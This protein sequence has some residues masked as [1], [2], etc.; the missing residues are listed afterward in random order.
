ML[1]SLSSTKTVSELKIRAKIVELRL[2]IT[3]FHLFKL[4]SDSLTMNLEPKACLVVFFPQES[5]H[6]ELKDCQ[7]EEST[8][9][10]SIYTG[11]E[12]YAA[13]TPSTTQLIY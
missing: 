7:P 6:E 3:V 11:Q 8:A 10:S 12:V 13:N 2:E 4:V 9:A 1:C 5:Q